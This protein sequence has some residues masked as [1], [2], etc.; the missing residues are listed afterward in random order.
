MGILNFINR[1]IDSK[2]NKPLKNQI[3]NKEYQ[4]IR[5]NEEDFW[6]QKYDLSTVE[7]IN[8]IPLPTK[9]SPST[10]SVT[11]TLDY[12]LIKKAGIYENSNQPDLSTQKNAI[13]VFRGILENCVVLMKQEL[14]KIK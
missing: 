4:Q 7:G 12:Y 9:K 3:S 5:Q 13:Y 2:N 1:F 8:S 14:K 10:D 6:E 11:S